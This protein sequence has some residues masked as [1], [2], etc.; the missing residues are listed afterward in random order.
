MDRATKLAWELLQFGWD[1]AYAF[2]YD[3]TQELPFRADRRDGRGSLWAQDPD[4]LDEL[5][6]RDYAAHPVPRE[7]AP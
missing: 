2:S 4:E 6:L 7:V 3:P 1:T 5:V